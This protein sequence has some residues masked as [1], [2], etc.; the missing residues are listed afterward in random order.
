MGFLSKKIS[1][2]KSLPGVVDRYNESTT[3]IYYK[4]TNFVYE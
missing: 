1:T 4:E 2:D 3:M